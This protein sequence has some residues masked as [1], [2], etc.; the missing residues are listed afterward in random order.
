MEMPKDKKDLLIQFYA[1]DDEE[2]EPFICGVCG[3]A[4][5]GYLELIEEE[6]IKYKEDYFDKG[7]G[8]YLFEVAKRPSEGGD[9]GETF[10]PEGFEFSE[11]KFTPEHQP[12][13]Q[14]N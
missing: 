11:I 10:Y 6:A 3:H 4:P 13:P 1:P 7:A 8:D 2:I 9:Y 12:E 14:H 5:I